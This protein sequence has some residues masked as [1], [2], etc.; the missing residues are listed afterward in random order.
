MG[1]TGSG[2]ST[3]VD[4][5]G[6]TSI[7]ILEPANGNSDYKAYPASLENPYLYT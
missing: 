7:L 3:K 1:V 6:R 2:D 5:S 4:A